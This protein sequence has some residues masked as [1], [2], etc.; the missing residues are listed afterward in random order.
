M[1]PRINYRY[2]NVR[3]DFSICVTTKIT[4]VIKKKLESKYKNKNLI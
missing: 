4:W 3:L 1:E 2:L